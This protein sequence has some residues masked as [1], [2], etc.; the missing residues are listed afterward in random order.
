MSDPFVFAAVDPGLSAA[1]GAVLGAL[2]T[3]AYGQFRDRS[4]A[5]KEFKAAV[6]LLGREIADAKEI[7]IAI[8]KTKSWPIG[9][10]PQWTK[11]WND[12]RTSIVNMISADEYDVVARVYVHLDQLEHSLK[13]GQGGREKSDEDDEFLRRGTEAPV[14][15]RPVANG[16]QSQPLGAIPGVH[17]LSSP[18]DQAI[19]VLWKHRAS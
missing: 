14:D 15:K 2:L 9:M 5:R 6:T 8:L 16:A 11:S 3:G 10:T 17:S 7:S 1:G 18:M 4:N 19:N 12:Y 13:D